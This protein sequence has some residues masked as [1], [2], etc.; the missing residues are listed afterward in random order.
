MPARNLTILILTTAVSMLCYHAAA[1]SHY[2]GLLAGAIGEISKTFVRPVDDRELFEGAMQ[3]MVRRLDPYSDYVSPEE[4]QEFQE[5]LNQNFG[6]IGIQV[7]LNRTTNRLTVLSPLP[8]TPAFAAGMRAGDQILEIEGQSTEGFQIRDAVDLMRGE[9]GTS[10]TIS[11]LHLGETE[12]VEMTMKRAIIPVA[13]VL[14]DV[15]N[16][17]GTWQYT[18]EDEPRIGF[19]RLATFGE[20]T[21]TELRETLVAIQSDIDGLILD[22]RGNGGGLL[23]AAIEVCDLFIDSGKIVSIRG[24]KQRNWRDYSAKRSATVLRE[25]P[26]VVLVD[27]YSA[28]ASEITAGCMQDHDRA[29]VVGTRTWGKG[30]VQNV[31]PF[32]GGRSALKLTVATYWRPSGQNIHRHIEATDEDPW[33]VTPNAG[34]AVETDDETLRKIVFLRRKRDR[35]KI[36]D[37]KLNRGNERATDAENEQTAEEGAAGGLQIPDLTGF[38]DPQVKRAVEAI[39][40]LISSAVPPTTRNLPHAG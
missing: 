32:E 30:T 10:L 22:V 23:T 29:I 11:V 39:K 18:L 27:G 38:E 21:A 31:V 2:G 6:G 16:S 17:D 13:S 35:V 7:E 37:T 14:G 1:R 33:G 25:L 5:D 24:R 40:D 8:D 12:P 4:L 28:S 26:M 19:I 3:G 34:Y 9:P 36:D 15:R 20:K